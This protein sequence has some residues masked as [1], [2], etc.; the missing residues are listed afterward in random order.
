MDSEI[1]AIVNSFLEAISIM[2][3]MRILVGKGREKN[4]LLYFCF[5]GFIAGYVGMVN[6]F[7]LNRVWMLLCYAIILVFF[8]WMYKLSLKRGIFLGILS[9][10]MVSLIELI[11]YIP[12]RLMHRIGLSDPYVSLVAVILTF[13]FCII[14]SKLDLL[15]FIRENLYY[16]ELKMY[17]YSILGCLMVIL[18]I[19]YFKHSGEMSFLE[20]I[21]LI[22]AMGIMFVA[23]YKISLY[24]RELL[25]QR[26]Y[27]KVY[28]EVIRE[29]RERQHKF[30]NQLDAIYS[31]F[32]LYDNYDELVQ[33]QKEM[34][35]NL[36]HYIMPTKLLILENPIVVAHVYQKMC[37]AIDNQIS[38]QMDFSCSVQNIAIP[39]IY[40]IEII[41]NL[42]DNAM[43]EIMLR[44]TDE[45]IYF[46]VFRS[47]GKICI[48]VCNEHEKIPFSEYKK[49]FDRGFS[50]KGRGHGEGLPYVRKI[51]SR[52][53]G[54]I[55]VGNIMIQDC[56]CFSIKIMFQE[57]MAEQG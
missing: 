56:S 50:T 16:I 2:L 53:D 5:Y 31:L 52:F 21:Y 30:T 41:G 32:Y 4:I 38:M 3:I 20:G 34:L 47:S 29:I 22:M 1:I 17:Y 37:E 12:L 15:F 23:A 14:L 39:E 11:L 46:S 48:Q 36:R 10:V 51:V 8:I 33:K 6:W 27:S 28:G 25:L 43:E 42:L 55:E 9:I 18:S 7:A 35:G 54:E 57:K 26:E 13:L 44:C 40:L 49:F 24:R 45:K 19:L